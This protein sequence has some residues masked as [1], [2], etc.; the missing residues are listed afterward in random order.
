LVEVEDKV[1]VKIEVK[2]SGLEGD[3]SLNAHQQE[4]LACEQEHNQRR[5]V[6]ETTLADHLLMGAPYEWELCF[7]NNVPVFSLHIQTL[8]K[9]PVLSQSQSNV[10]TKFELLLIEM[11]KWLYQNH[12]VTKLHSQKIS[13][14]P[15]MPFNMNIDRNSHLMS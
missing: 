9:V 4:N 10:R 3:H 2:R 13:T 11:Q 1:K 14:S 15:K 6:L 12:L 7:A 8:Q 5:C